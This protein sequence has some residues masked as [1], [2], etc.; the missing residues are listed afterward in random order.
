L[1]STSSKEHRDRTPFIGREREIGLLLDELGRGTGLIT[2][3]GPSG[4][5]KTRLVLQVQS[6]VAKTAA[7]DGRTRFCNLAAAQ[8]TAD[9]EGVVAHVL[10][11]PGQ[12]GKDLAR[13]LS[14][15]GDLLL[16]LDNLDDVADR[17]GELLGRWIDSCPQLQILATSI[18][19]L[20]LDGEISFDLGPLDLVD[21]T[22]LYLERARRA[23][24]ARSFSAEEEPTIR[25]LVGRLDRIPLAIEL[26]A[27]RVQ[28][29]PPRALLSQL[30]ERFELLRSEGKGRHGSL[31]EA[32]TLTWGYLSAQ[33]KAALARA[34]IFEGGFTYEAACQVLGDD[35]AGV[36]TLELLSDLRSKA[37][38]Q[39][40]ES[41][42]PRFS[43]FESIKDFAAKELL[44]TGDH[45]ETLRRHAAYFVEHGA[46]Q[47]ADLDGPRAMEASAWLHV[48]SE[49]LLAVLHRN[50]LTS[51]LVAANAGLAISA[52]ALANEGYVPSTFHLVETTLDAARRSGDPVLLARALGNHAKT[53]MDVREDE[54]LAELEE[55]LALARAAAAPAV[56]GELLIRLALS[57]W[58]RRDLEQTSTLIDRA[59]AIGREERV[60]QIEARALLGRAA[61][62]REA[63]AFDEVEQTNTRILAILRRHGFL[64]F[65]ALALVWMGSFW[66]WQGRF[67]AARRALHDAVEKCRTQ[68]VDRL[69]EANALTNLGALELAAGN[70]EE[71]RRRSLEALAIQRE[72]GN[73]SGEGLALGN[74]GNIALESDD[75]KLAEE[76][77]VESIS[78]HEEA[79]SRR[80]QAAVLPFLAVVEMR[81]GRAMEARRSLD[82]ALAFFR[83][84]DDQ[85]SLAA[86]ELLEGALELEEARRLPPTR[87]DETEPLVRHAR[88]RL[89]AARRQGVELKGAMFEAIRLLEKDL[90]NWEAG[91]RESEEKR[92]VEGLRVGPKAEWFQLPGQERVELRRRVALRRL[93]DAL[94]TR[95]LTAPGIAFSPHEL[96]ERG[97]P[98]VKIQPES[99]MSRLYLAVWKLRALGLTHVLLNQTDGYLLDPE[100]PLLRPSEE[101]REA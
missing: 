99:A 50:L 45:Q 63:G 70:L 88:Q 68:L 34:S 72:L 40:E 19:P 20:G 25:E 21:A 15:R 14:R 54:A 24:P 52:L 97:W 69:A 94:A 59:V 46:A 62:A 41:S 67:R 53:I 39:I 82:E 79:S 74:L 96:F 51:P 89:E 83:E 7:S 55:G 75:L 29:C 61:I 91:S 17:I 6:E 73:R 47:A 1:T 76:Y 86:A 90:K 77:L 87:I 93:L 95:R 42:P 38:L 57:S 23:W 27:A 66:I 10:G 32:L 58:A 28:V 65:E 30:D 98:N 18:V 44:R 85:P 2:L 5:G 9:V 101:R 22:A 3:C 11:I 92:Q 48:E 84:I 100:V 4:M 26:A 71:A 80:Y 81:M 56:E 37:L 13:A 12:S 35:A 49:N 8:E 64:R 43:L 31:L 78:L 60:P 33:E 36:G 16:V